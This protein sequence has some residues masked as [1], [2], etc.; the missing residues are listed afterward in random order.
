MS[1]AALWLNYCLSAAIAFAAIYFLGWRIV[2]AM[3]AGTIATLA[4]WLLVSLA[5]GGSLGDPTLEPALIVNGSLGLVFAAA[6]AAAAFAARRGS[7]GS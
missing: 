7:S 3:L 6:G 1:E 5:S 2:S 4:L